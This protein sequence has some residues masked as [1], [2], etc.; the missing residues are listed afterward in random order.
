MS[1]K[2]S[3]IAFFVAGL[4]LWPI[5]GCGF[6]DLMAGVRTG[7]DGEVITS[8]GI[9]STGIG[10][11]G[12]LGPWGALAGQGAMLGLTMYKHKRIIALGGKDANVNGIEDSQEKKA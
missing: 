12:L 3:A 4:L 7:P 6:L 11:L 5:V 2:R 1:I 8:D 9:A 10:L